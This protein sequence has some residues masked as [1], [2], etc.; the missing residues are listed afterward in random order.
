M[1]AHE[2]EHKGQRF[3]LTP[4]QL[5]AEKRGRCHLHDVFGLVLVAPRSHTT[6]SAGLFTFGLAT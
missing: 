2:S 4:V 5:V 6:C 1:G 3:M